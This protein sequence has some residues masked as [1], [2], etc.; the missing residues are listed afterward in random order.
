MTAIVET[1]GTDA[2]ELPAAQAQAIVLLAAGLSVTKTAEQLGVSRRTIARWFGERTFQASYAAEVEAHIAFVRH[3]WRARGL[4]LLEKSLDM[5]EAALDAGGA[6]GLVAARIVV[7]HADGLDVSTDAPKPPSR[8]RDLPTSE[9][10]ARA[11]ELRKLS[12]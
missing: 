5:L 6:A 3:T 9:L 10:V 8:A 7:S 4:V 12:R 2:A 1:P 11:I